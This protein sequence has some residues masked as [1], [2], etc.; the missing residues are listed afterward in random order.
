[1]ETRQLAVQ[2]AARE[3]VSIGAC[4]FLGEVPN[5]AMR[6]EACPRVSTT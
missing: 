2:A 5:S 3:N 6:Q 1:M 4:I